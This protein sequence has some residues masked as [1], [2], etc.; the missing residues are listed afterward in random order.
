M[1]PPDEQTIQ[2]IYSFASGYHLGF[3]DSAQERRQHLELGA[4]YYRFMKKFKTNGKLL[5]VGCSAGFFLSI[6]REDGWQVTGLELSADTAQLAKELYQLDVRT[7]KLEVDTFDA[8]SFEAVTFWDVIEHVRDPLGTMR[9]VNRILKERGIVAITTPNVD[10]LFPRTSYH[11]A[12]V[13]K[14]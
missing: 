14:L 10:G 5:D 12:P 7:G 1:D 13:A 4:Q 2:R 9:I 3:R 11:F 8:E 6:A